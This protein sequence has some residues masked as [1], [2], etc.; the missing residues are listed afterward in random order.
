MQVAG[1]YAVEKSS[2]PLRVF[3]MRNMLAT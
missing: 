3:L 1:K 2:T